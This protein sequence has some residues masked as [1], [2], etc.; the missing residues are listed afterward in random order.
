[1]AKP[2]KLNP[3][4]FVQEVHNPF[5]PP[6]RP[7]EFEDLTDPQEIIK[8][9]SEQLRDA[10]NERFVGSKNT[11]QAR[12]DMSRVLQEALEH[13]KQVESFSPGFGIKNARI[14]GDNL[15]MDILMPSPAPFVM[16][17]V[18]SDEGQ[19]EIKVEKVEKKDNL[20]RIS[21]PWKF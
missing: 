11:P 12:A 10:I 1:M 5:G 21:A 3:G 6:V 4:V 14:E 2:V 18:L 16:D 19:E 7:E 15:V 9:V 8:V 17:F 13:V 20:V